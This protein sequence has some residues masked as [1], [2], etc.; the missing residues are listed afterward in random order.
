MKD[1]KLYI[2]LWQELAGHKAMVFLVGPRQAGKTTLARMIAQGFSNPVYFNW[3]LVTNKRLLIESPTF[4]EKI[5]RKDETAPLVIFDEIHKYRKWKNYLKGVYDQ[6]SDGYKFLVLGSGRLDVFQK[7]GD[8]LA[9]RYFQFNLWPFTLAEL[10]D[11]RRP[12]GEFVKDPQRV[13]KEKGAIETIWNQLA[14]F[15]GFPEPYLSGKETVYRRWSRNYHRQLIREDIRNTTEIK[16]IDETEILFSLLPSKVG[17]PLSLD[18][19]A[20]DLQVSFKTIRN[21]LTV[22]ESFFLTFR[23]APWT[24][25]I[26][27]AI[28]KERKLYLYDYAVIQDPAARFENMVALELL[29]AVSNWNDWG[30]GDFSIHYVRNKDKEEVD[31]LIAQDAKPLLLVECKFSEES[32]SKGLLKFQGMLDIPAVQL[33]NKPGVYRSISTG[34][35]KVLIVTA[36]RWLAGL[37]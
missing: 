24:R 1:R 8:S 37:P 36:S 31:F 29:R 13:P 7:G 2:K 25:K 21:W 35:H 28:T 14:R 16:N 9:G 4:F 22:F 34:Q 3:D 17:S 5:D 10:V 23:I 32:V 6:F 12:F 11:A 26:S 15:S 33:V 20:R 18:S 27:R 19:L 30:R